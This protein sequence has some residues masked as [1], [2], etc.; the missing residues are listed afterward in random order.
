MV[1][2]KGCPCLTPWPQEEPEVGKTGTST[3]R[4]EI[5][6]PE[7]LLLVVFLPGFSTSFTLSLTLAPSS[8]CTKLG[9]GFL[10]PS[11]L[12]LCQES[13]SVYS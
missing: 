2:F 6:S 1:A 9:L 12:L 3:R 4:R 10:T 13:G 11:F 5:V 8:R 7:M